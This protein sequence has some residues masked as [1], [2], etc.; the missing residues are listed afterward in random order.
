MTPMTT[1]TAYG[2]VITW[3]HDGEPTGT[4]GPRRSTFTAEQIKAEGR[5]FRMLDDDGEHYY[6]GFY[7]GPDDESMFGP[8]D[9]FGMPNAGATSI[10][11]RNP[12]GGW[13]LL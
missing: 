10:E 7:L 3:T 12:A 1:T 8:L 13:D 6:R 5:E 4:H 2:W 9:D 11:Y